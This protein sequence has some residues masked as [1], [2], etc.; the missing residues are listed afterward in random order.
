MNSADGTG[1]RSLGATRVVVLGGGFGGMYTALHLERLAAKGAAVD[2]SLVNRENY[3]VFQPMLAEVIAGD[4]GILDTVSPLRQ[5][6]PNTNLFVR[7]IE[8]VDIDR[9]VVRLG[10]GLTPQTHEL[11]FDHLVVA[12]GNV[13]DFRGIPGLPEHALPF[14]TLADSVRIRNHVINVLEQSSVVAD[15]QA[16]RTMLTFVV[17][18]G[19]FSGTEVAAALNDFVR[20]A[21]RHYRSIPREEVRIVLVHSGKAVLDRELTP[22]L[23]RYSTRALADQGIEL[24]LGERLV[25][26][27]PH[28]A[29][30]SSGQ[31][32]AT[33]TLISTV[34]SSPNPVVQGLGLQS[35]RG[36]LECDATLAVKNCERVWA[37][38]DCAQVPMPGGEPCPPTAQHAIRQAKVLAANIV[39]DHV[40]ARRRSFAFKGLGK[41]GALG[42]HRAVAELPGGIT[43]EGVTAWL[44]WRGIYWAKLPGASRKTRVAVSWLSDMVL[45][46]HPVQLNLGGGRGATQAHYEPGEVVFEEGDAGDSLLMILSGQVEVI[47]RVGAADQQIRTLGPGEYFGEMALLG[48]QPRS[49]TTRALTALDLLVLPASDF[50]ALAGSLDEFRG[51][52]EQIAGARAEADAARTASE[53]A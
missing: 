7:E 28:G 11:K 9:R 3:L 18:G 49:A 53:P 22:R 34:P 33:R 38:G 15:P 2:V 46:S 36:R 32:I 23:A 47:K 10:A 40:G 25:A 24:L 21:T 5:L 51:Q 30:L 19:G 52:F 35:V 42:H 4:V 13:T 41:L 50:A 29:V 16:R 20:N 27:S 45:P 14:K 17:A 48:R 6:L 39:A 1:R 37:T 44:M 8:G 26:A 43:V 12:L 31:R